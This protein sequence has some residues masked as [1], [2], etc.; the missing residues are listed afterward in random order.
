MSSQPPEFRSSESIRNEL[1]DAL[2]ELAELGELW[3]ETHAEGGDTRQIERAIVDV[4]QQT[5]RLE[6]KLR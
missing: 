4:T 3:F 5:R 1:D 6:R 2:D